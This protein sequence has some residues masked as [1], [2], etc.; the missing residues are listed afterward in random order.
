ME[1]S[2]N[3][4]ETLGKIKDTLS[5]L[6]FEDEL[7]QKL[8]MPVPDDSQLSPKE[9]WTSCHCFDTAVPPASVK[10]DQA[11]LCLETEAPLTAGAALQVRITIHAY[12]RGSMLRMTEAMK[13]EYASAYGLSGNRI[14]MALAAIHRAVTADET[15]LRTFGTGMMHLAE[16]KPVT[17]LWQ[18]ERFYGKSLSYTICQMPIRPKGQVAR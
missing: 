18:D 8:I 6:F 12:A 16:E 7:V 3:P 1:R 17:S 14:D 15:L 13:Q 4:L 10:E 5:D 11:F 2:K 9:N